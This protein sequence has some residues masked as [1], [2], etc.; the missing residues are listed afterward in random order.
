MQLFGNNALF[1][2][3]G[4]SHLLLAIHMSY[5]ITRR[6]APDSEESMDYQ[7]GPVAT[8]GLST[9]TYALD[10]RSDA[11]TYMSDNEDEVSNEPE[12]KEAN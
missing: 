3:I 7:V 1:Q 8:V 6:E 12:D 5:R 9:E 4:L 10:P 11:E 2:M